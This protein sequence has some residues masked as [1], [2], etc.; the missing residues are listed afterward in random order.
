MDPDELVKAFA[1]RPALHRFPASNARRVQE[2]CRVIVDEYDGDAARIWTTAATGEQ[3]LGRIRD[4]PGFGEQKARIFVG[5]LG[6]QLGV[7]PPGWQQAAG[8]F[9][10]PA[11]HLSVADITD[12][13]SLARVRA[14][15]QALKAAARTA[16]ATTTT[17]KTADKTAAKA[18]RTSAKTSAK[19]AKVAEPAR[20]A[21]G[22]RPA[23][24]AKPAKSG[25]PVSPV[26][27]A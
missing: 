14:Y 13:E 27:P 5:L 25:T 16:E 10:E 8:R 6:K 7:Q 11:T 18:T 4:L 20:A 21:K 15:K 23:P 19:T 1:E 2:L 26:P 9:G 22:A 12:A 24:V 3:L 17:E